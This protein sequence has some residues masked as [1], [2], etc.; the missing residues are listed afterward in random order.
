MNMDLSNAYITYINLDSRED[1]RT[2]MVDQL[3]RSGLPYH[4]TKAVRIDKDPEELGY[5]PLPRLQGQ[6][7]FL[8][9]WL[10]HRTALETAVLSGHEG[11]Y[12]ILED[13]VRI[14]EKIWSKG[15]AAPPGDGWEIL[16]LSPRFRKRVREEGERKWS[17]WP[18]EGEYV[19]LARAQEEYICTGAHFCIV[20]SK[21]AALRIIEKMDESEY[22]YDVD[23]FYVK[24]T[25]SFGIREKKVSTADMGSDH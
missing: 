18:F 14:N 1:R 13:D 17:P 11:P 20:K 9:I 21:S 25:K 5:K 15:V 22:V 10:S 23:L 3:S 6:R 8:G 16:L 24:N 7:N 2:F 12:V 4:R 19:E